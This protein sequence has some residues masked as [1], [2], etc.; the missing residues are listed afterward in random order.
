MSSA[1]S[2]LERAYAKMRLY[3]KMAVF[4]A[5]ALFVI[6]CVWVFA[7]FKDGQNAL[8]TVPS[9]KRPNAKKA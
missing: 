7:E 1:Q 2:E 4:F 6:A 3:L 8:K 5:S 9:S